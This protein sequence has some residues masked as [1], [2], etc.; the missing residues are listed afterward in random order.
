M[1]MGDYKLF[2][3]AIRQED[4]A[5]PLN[6]SV[7]DLLTSREEGCHIYLAIQPRN[8]F[9][10]KSKQAGKVITAKLALNYGP[11]GNF[12]SMYHVF[13]N[14]PEALNGTGS[15]FVLDNAYDDKRFFV[16]PEEAAGIWTEGDKVRNRFT[17]TGNAEAVFEEL[18]SEGF[19]FSAGQFKVRRQ[20]RGDMLIQRLK[21]NGV[22]HSQLNPS[23]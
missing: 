2:K 14:S 20:N 17:L 12:S 7:T 19:E 16:V 10:R 6:V 11:D 5:N 18:K 3:M 4:L 22:Y 13:L 15:V 1:F 21:E 9:E 8:E 23:K